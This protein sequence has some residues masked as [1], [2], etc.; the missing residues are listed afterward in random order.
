MK[1]AI[2]KAELLDSRVQTN[3]VMLQVL[4]LTSS[5]LSCVFSARSADQCKLIISP[6]PTANFAWP[7]DVILGHREVIWP[8]GNF[9]SSDNKQEI[10]G[11][12]RAKKAA[13]VI[14]NCT[15]VGES[16]DISEILLR[17]RESRVTE[18]L[19]PSF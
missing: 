18:V 16:A 15:T 4:Q 1:H 11:F 3:Y 2:T 12:S 7:D 10:E 14:E 6:T 8:A 19:E 13:C 17:S 9:L 5:I